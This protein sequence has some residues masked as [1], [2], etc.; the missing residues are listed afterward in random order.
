[1]RKQ[2]NFQVNRLRYFEAAMNLF[3]TY[4]AN[5][6][7]QIVD[8]IN[9]LNKNVPTYEMILNGIL[10]YWYGDN[11]LKRRNVH[12]VLNRLFYLHK[13]QM[14]YENAYE[15]FIRKLYSYID[16]ICIL[17]TGYLAMNLIPKSQLN[18]M[19]IQIKR[20]VVKTKPQHDLVIEELHLY[21]EMKLMTFDI[22]DSSDLTV[23]FL[24]FINPTLC[25]HFCDVMYEYKYTFIL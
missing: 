18:G 21:Y 3:G 4:N 8:A 20:A 5:S 14:R 13:L 2:Q 15:H 17:S 25:H 16:A 6:M 11:I 9:T 10:S 12:M 24:V 7:D 22:D 19:I 23:Q 1:M